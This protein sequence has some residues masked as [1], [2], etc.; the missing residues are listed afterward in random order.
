MFNLSINN[1]EVL[2]G[3]RGR[4]FACKNSRPHRGEAF[5]IGEFNRDN[6]VCYIHGYDFNLSAANLEHMKSWKTR[7]QNGE[8]QVIWF[9]ILYSKKIEVSI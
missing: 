7:A 6:I 8:S 3:R 4:L 2:V 5:C 1:S 9:Y